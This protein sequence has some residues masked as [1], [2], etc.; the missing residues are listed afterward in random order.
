[1]SQC[2]IRAATEEDL[3][4][5]LSLLADDQKGASRED[6][7]LPL[8]PGYLAAFAAMQAD[9]NQFLAVAEK[10]GAVIGVFQLTFIPGLSRR[11]AWRGQIESVRI[12]RAMRGTGL[13]TE[14]MEWAIAACRERGCKLV[15]L[16]SDQDREDAHRFYSA[17]GFTPSHTGFKMNL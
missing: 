8:A 17:L 9:P 6:P 13:G 2:H 4:T 15:Q 3:P 5:I 1:M 11:G 16:T 7:S 14:M 10:A 12:H